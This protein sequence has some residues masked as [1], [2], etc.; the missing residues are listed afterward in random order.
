MVRTVCIAPFDKRCRV[1]I[2]ERNAIGVPN[3]AIVFP[4]YDRC[5]DVSDLYAGV[6]VGLACES[7]FKKAINESDV[8]LITDCPTEHHGYLEDIVSAAIDRERDVYYYNSDLSILSRIVDETNRHFI[9]LPSSPFSFSQT[10]E[11]AREG[12]STFSCPCVHIVSLCSG[13][14]TFELLCHVRDVMRRDN[15][16]IV[17]L[18]ESLYCDAFGL[19]RMVLSDSTEDGVLQIN[20]CVQELVYQVHPDLVVVE[21]PN[22]VTSYSEY[23]HYDFGL[24]SHALFR[25]VPPDIV[26][27]CVPLNLVNPAFLE[28]C[29]RDVAAECGTS[30]C[31]FIVG[32]QMVDDSNQ[33]ELR[34][35]GVCY[36]DDAEASIRA[37]AFRLAGLP[38]YTLRSKS[39]VLEFDRRLREILTDEGVSFI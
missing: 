14:D 16:G 36:S 20:A 8:V 38:T 34:S 4:S 3:G 27:C 33:V 32:D 31:I 26:L 18:S 29:L 7:D 1:F 19:R 11:W 9:H 17:A 35:L 12:F 15:L 24:S 23:V 21:H 37:S 2:T 5:D 28:E 6:P 39:E 30:N 25:A 10:S 13:L 22:P